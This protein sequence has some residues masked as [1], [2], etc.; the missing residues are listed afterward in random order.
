LGKFN[1][2]EGQVIKN[3]IDC[4]VSPSGSNLTLG[5]FGSKEMCFEV[6]YSK[7]RNE[8]ANNQERV[9]SESFC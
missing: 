1:Y 8:S 6:D 2:K 3:E 5:A 9:G 7:E 4:V